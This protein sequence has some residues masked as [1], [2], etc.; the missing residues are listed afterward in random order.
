MNPYVSSATALEDFHL[1]LTFE[2]GEERIFDLKPL[3]FAGRFPE[4]VQSLAF[5]MCS[6]CVRIG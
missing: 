3:S 2:N 4:I 5:P 1:R 6:S